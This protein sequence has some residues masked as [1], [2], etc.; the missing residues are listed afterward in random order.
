MHGYANFIDA[1]NVSL[2]LYLQ[3]E[4]LHERYFH[5]DSTTSL[6]YF[7]TTYDVPEIIREIRFCCI[8]K[9]TLCSDVRK[10]DHTPF[11]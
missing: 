6:K 5:Y 4:N 11:M 10:M 7:T 3:G 8:M 2:V 9:F 1:E